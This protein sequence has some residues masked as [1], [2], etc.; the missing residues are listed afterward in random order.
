MT[1]SESEP[2]TSEPGSQ[3][4]R[5]AHAV[6]VFREA[7]PAALLKLLE[8]L[9]AIKR[10]YASGDETSE[11]ECP[12][13]SEPLED[14][15]A[16][17][18]PI[19]RVGPI[20]VALGVEPTTG[21]S[22]FGSVHEDAIETVDDLV[23]ALGETVERGKLP[24]VIAITD[25]ADHNGF[26]H[27]SLLL[28]NESQIALTVHAHDAAARRTAVIAGVHDVALYPSVRRG[29]PLADVI[30]VYQLEARVRYGARADE[31]SCRLE[32]DGGT[33]INFEEPYSALCTHEDGD[34][35]TFGNGERVRVMICKLRGAG[36]AASQ[37]GAQ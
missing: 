13:C 5:E 32:L 26:W 37:G 14:P 3:A 28:R 2:V 34:D 33:T 30:G 22:Q 10:D 25:E 1:M 16:D 11:W 17:D 29:Y 36:P 6:G 18:C 31:P 35:G 9:E 12:I 21:G 24:G 7:P 19:G 15:H 4:A 23:E 20:L 27:L 8:L